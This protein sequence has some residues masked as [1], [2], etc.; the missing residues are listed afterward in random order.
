MFN[1]TK[2]DMHRL[3]HSTTTWITIIF[4][5]IIAIFGVAMTDMDI[6]AS[7]ENPP[8][9]IEEM[10]TEQQVGITV[11]GNPEWASGKVELGDIISMEMQSGLITI[12]CV[13]FAALFA[14]AEQK[15]GYIK[16]IGGQFP[17]RWKLILSKF[18]AIAVQTFVLLFVFVAVTAATSILFWGNQV[19]VASLNPLLKVLG[20]QYL[21]HTGL[22]T[23][24]MFLSILTRSTAFSTTTGILLCSGLTA[25]LY[26]GVNQVI[27]NVKPTWNF[28]I[29]NYVLESNIR[30]IGIDTISD[31]MLRSA[32]V[33]IVFVIV[34][35]VFSMITI[36]K[37]DIR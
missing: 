32:I 8:A 25:F 9:A 16:N 22:A 15:N 29:N 1:L 20:I 3:L 18:L 14:N 21:L 27:S 19:Y 36:Q 10:T 31:V 12:L 35:I 11:T 5:I 24:I 2:M 6:Q 34:F 17:K 13:I 7:Q 23:L 28:D 26:S 30:G 4:A 37:R 33:G